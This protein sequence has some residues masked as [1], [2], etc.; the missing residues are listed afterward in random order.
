M[1][2]IGNLSGSCMNIDPSELEQARARFRKWMPRGNPGQCLWLAD[3]LNSTPEVRDFFL[4]TRL[5][6][7]WPIFTAS[8]PDLIGALAVMS[9]HSVRGYKITERV[10][11][12]WSQ[13]KYRETLEANGKK[14]YNY[15]MSIDAGEKLQRLANA[16]QRPINKTLEMLIDLQHDHLAETGIIRAAAKQPTPAELAVTPIFIPS[17]PGPRPPA[18]EPYPN[19]PDSP[20]NQSVR[21]A[22]E[23]FTRNNN[24]RQAAIEAASRKESQDNYLKSATAKLSLT[25]GA[26]KES[27][28]SRK[29]RLNRRLYQ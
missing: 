27:P 5:A 19:D 25:K 26:A 17:G 14:T 16:C 9:T 3:Y 24:A 20:I 22:E 6:T 18:P 21:R 15:V 4:S 2:F 7:H 10:R 1:I 13:Q 8:Y 23:S 28:E 11:S 12:A 29:E